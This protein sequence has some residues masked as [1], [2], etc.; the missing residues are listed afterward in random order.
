MY[1]PETPLVI[2]DIETGGLELHHP[3]IQIAAVVF[4]PETDVVLQELELKIIFDEA[5]CDEEALKI[6]NY[7]PVDWF[8]AISIEDAMRLL[9]KL[10]RDFATTPRQAKKGGQY[11]VAIAAGYNSKFDSDRLLHQARQRKMFLPVDPRFLDVMQLAMWKLCLPSYKL[12]HVAEY[13]GIPTTN[14]HDALADV[15]M[16]YKVMKKLLEAA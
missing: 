12:I 16:T 3:I 6:N 14:A 9:L 1:N 2:I 13:L 15:H 11:N 5:E 7:N 10:L 4:L 8:G